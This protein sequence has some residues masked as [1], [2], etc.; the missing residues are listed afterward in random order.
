MAVG[1]LHAVRRS[2]QA[3]SAMFDQD[4]WR[5]QIAEHLR[6]FAR[7]PRQE[8]QLDGAPSLLSFLVLRTLD[9][10]LEA[11]Q[12]VDSI[13]DPPYLDPVEVA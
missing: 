3:Q 6:G 13:V 12:R 1:L 7:N 5:R 8:M 10:F 2:A 11:F 9:P 4:T